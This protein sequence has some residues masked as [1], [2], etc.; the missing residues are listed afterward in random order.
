MKRNRGMGEADKKMKKN[1]KNTLRVESEEK[2]NLN[3]K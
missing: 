3:K 1:K 2:K